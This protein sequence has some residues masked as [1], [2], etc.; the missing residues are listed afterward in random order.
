M[1][2]TPEI[3]YA[4]S[5]DVHIAF[6]TFG[7][8][9]VLLGAPGFISHLE[10]GW[11]EPGLVDFWERLA[12]VRRIV[13]FDK[14]GVGLSDPIDHAP[15]LEECV[16]DMT[17]VL[18]AAGVDDVDLFGVSEGGAMAML[19]SA[20]Y[21]ERVRSL[22]LYGTYARML[23]ADDYP[24]GVSADNYAS[25]LQF[26]SSG[27]GEGRGLG[28]WAPSRRGDTALRQWWARLQRLAASPGMVR[29]IFELYP[30]IDVR[31]VLGAIQAPTLVLHRTGD[32]MI[33][34]HMG[35]Y[36]ADHI[37]SATL[38]ELPGNDHLFW[39]E[40]PEA[41]LEEMEEFLTGERHIARPDR[42]L[43]TVLF[44]DVVQSTDR[45][46]EMGDRRWRDLLG[47]HHEQVRR[48]LHR[49]G[50]REVN[51]TGDGF[52]A[53]F[54]GPARAIR[55]ARSVRD[56]VR[57]LGLEVRAGLHTGEIEVKSGDISGVAVH[58][59]ARVAALARPNEVLVSRTVTDLVAG[60]GIE[61]HDRGEHEL[62]G[63]PGTWQ[64][65]SA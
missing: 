41:L 37:P 27:W 47:A 50:G 2:D 52:L 17:A 35:R 14:R 57:G 22:T 21:P 3:R 61:F 63:V 65:F 6:T 59:A 44:T 34:I 7:E 11:E 24:F 53:T 64:L 55:C 36:L 38:V 45:L 43:A 51:T 48:Q 58:V 13:L 60:S 23:E 20:T 33:N 25:L 39:T 49:F 54:D 28:A 4:K 5:G 30:D 46:V 62:K 56:A 26:S 31:S 1:S 9:D 42:V 8:G 10:V 15:T 40:E 32:R 16:D 29:R 19:F 18:G 12:R